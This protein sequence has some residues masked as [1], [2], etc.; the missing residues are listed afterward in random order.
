MTNARVLYFTM[1]V[2][3]MAATVFGAEKRVKMENLPPAVQKTVQQQSKGATIRGLSQDVEDG[4]TFYEAELKVNGH[5]KDLLIDATGA[6]VEI[7]EEVPLDSVPAAAK[8][9]IEKGA[10]K[11]KI[12]TVESVTQ[13]NSIVAYEAKIK[14]AGKNSEV[15]VTPDGAPAKEP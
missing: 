14:T 7:E 2:V 9:A 13:N 8:A 6:V 10:R 11:G 4:K 1:P 3:L 5:N 12:A 15:R